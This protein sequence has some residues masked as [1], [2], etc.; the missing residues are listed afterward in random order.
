VRLLPELTDPHTT[1]QVLLERQPGLGGVWAPG[2][3]ANASS[4][5]QISEPNYRMV[6]ENIT[7]EFTPQKELLEQMQALAERDGFGGRI[8]YGATVT[9]VRTVDALGQETQVGG[10]AAVRVTYTDAGGTAHVLLARDHVLLCT[11]GLQTPKEITLP[12]EQAFG[13]DVI[14]GIKSEV[15]NIGLSGRRVCVL[16]LG[17]FA[18]ENARTALLHVTGHRHP[19]YTVHLPLNRHCNPGINGQY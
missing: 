16:G 1:G 14:L 10:G 17:A 6:G 3:W 12:D 2:S 15:D 19:S 18:V 7:S 9:A 11:G 13:G 4:R 8:R 5:V